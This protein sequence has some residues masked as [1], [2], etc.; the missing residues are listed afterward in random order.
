MAKG[1]QNG[2]A[3]LIGVGECQDTQ[4]SLPGTVK[5]TKAIYKALINPKICGYPN[6]ED[7]IR[8]LTNETA[9]RDRIIEGLQWLQKIAKENSK[10]TILIYYSGH[11]W[12]QKEEDCYYLLPHNTQLDNPSKTAL[13]GEE[14]I[15]ALEKIKVDRLLAIVD[16]CHAARLSFSKAP[17]L[18]FRGYQPVSPANFLK[19]RLDL[20]RGKVIFASCK[21]NEK[22]WLRKD[23]RSLY[24]YHFL[25]A[26]KGA[27]NKPGDTEVKV[28]N[29][30]NYVSETV[31]NEVQELYGEQQTPYFDFK[32]NDF[33]IALLNGGRGLEPKRDRE[34]SSNS[35]NIHQTGT[36]N[37]YIEN[38]RGVQ[39]GDRT[40]YQDSEFYHDSTVYKNSDVQFGD[41]VF[42][43]DGSQVHIGD[44]YYN[45]A[46]QHNYQNINQE[47]SDNQASTDYLNR[48]LAALQRQGCSDLRADVTLGS[49]TFKYIARISEY[50]LP[51]LPNFQLPFGIWNK[52]G[53]AFFMV[54]EYNELTKTGL[55]KFAAQCFE[56]ARSQVTANTAWQ[57]FYNGR[58]PTHCCFAIAIVDRLD[59]ETRTAIVT[60]NPLN[61]RAN[62][63]WY[64][65]PAVYDLSQQQLYYYQKSDNFF[66]D[67]VGKGV[68]ASLR[69]A[70]DSVFQ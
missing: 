58:E 23:F 68:W 26:L 38:A 30:M 12:I 22:S 5:D 37:N 39:F 51:P 52:R 60:S 35:R 61:T 47:C 46:E 20:D 27:G 67:I 28:S 53:E 13:A 36:T 62:I 69:Q 50:E 9:T 10:A 19:N 57:A 42:Y 64:Q 65:I 4:L 3:L 41:R 1:F 11:G 48:V 29:I 14:F 56:W 25:K 24:T 32:D 54:S 49:L 2:Y 66:E 63:L 6:N 31:K 59:E 34:P 43:S 55:D 8:I 15:E 16:S 44:R 33:P 40:Y 7:H 45:S 21:E 18:D 70:M 17:F